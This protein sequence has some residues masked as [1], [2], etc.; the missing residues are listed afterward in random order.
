MKIFLV[1]GLE[2]QDRCITEFLQQTAK[3]APLAYAWI[4]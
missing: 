3:I 1:R 2:F 4:V